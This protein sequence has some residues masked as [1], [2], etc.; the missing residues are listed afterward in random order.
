VNPSSVQGLE[1]SLWSL[2]TVVAGNANRNYGPGVK[3]WLPHLSIFQQL[4]GGSE[5][6]VQQSSPQ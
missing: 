4:F 5:S 2:F 3:L 1:L 6:Q